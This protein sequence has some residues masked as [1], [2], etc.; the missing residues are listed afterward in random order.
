MLIECRASES[1][2]GLFPLLSAQQSLQQ[3]QDPPLCKQSAFRQ[4]N[5]LTEPEEFYL[6]EEASLKP[7]C[8]LLSRAWQ[9]A[10][11]V[12]MIHSHPAAHYHVGPVPWPCGMGVGWSCWSWSWS[13]SRGGCINAGCCE[14]PKYTHLHNMQKS[15]HLSP[16]F[17]WQ[18]SSQEI[19]C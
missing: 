12:T 7:I 15:S 4:G 17:F 3:L 18:G 11:K 13:W 10:L 8:L 6:W 5:H 19:S 1:M 14:V 9:R 2:G 16:R